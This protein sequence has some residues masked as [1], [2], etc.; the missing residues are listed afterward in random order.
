MLVPGFYLGLLNQILQGEGKAPVDSG[1]CL[2]W[3]RTISAVSHSAL[4]LPFPLH[5]PVWVKSKAAVKSCQIY[6]LARGNLA[7]INM[8]QSPCSFSIHEFKFRRKQVSHLGRTE[9]FRKNSEFQSPSQ[10]IHFP[11]RGNFFFP[12][13]KMPRI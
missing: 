8:I 5:F 2:G 12:K 11:G 7:Q 3:R 10:G 13:Q 4:T 9:I 1:P 6:H